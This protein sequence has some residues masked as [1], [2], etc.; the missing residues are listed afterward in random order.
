MAA[1]TLPRRATWKRDLAP[2]LR[3]D[4]RR[5]LGQIAS[6]VVPY[7]ALWGLAALVQPAPWLL[8]VL[9]VVVLGLVWAVAVRGFVLAGAWNPEA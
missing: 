1:S 9:L 7:L 4:H 2:Y 3:I 6:V 8:A 5:S